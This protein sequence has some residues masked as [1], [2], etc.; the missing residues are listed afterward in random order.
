MNNIY[1]GC[2]AKDTIT[3]YVGIVVCIS[4]WLNGCRRV[5]IQAK[6]LKG[7]IPLENQTFDVEQ[8]NLVSSGLQTQASPTGGPSIRPTRN[9]DPV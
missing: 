7:G 5:T 8:V 6:E 3:G 9:A 4:D 2:E 1:L